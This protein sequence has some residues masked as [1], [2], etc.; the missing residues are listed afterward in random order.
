MVSQIS[1]FGKFL[2]QEE[3]VIAKAHSINDIN[4]LLHKNL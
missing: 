3:S 1:F 2:G 4:T